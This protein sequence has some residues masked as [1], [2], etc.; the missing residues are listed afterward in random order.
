MLPC[1][2]PP[3]WIDGRWVRSRRGVGR[4][5]RGQR[6]EG[7]TPRRKRERCWVCGQGSWC[8]WCNDCLSFLLRC[9][10]LMTR[11]SSSGSLWQNTGTRSAGRR[12]SDSAAVAD[13]SLPPCETSPQPLLFPPPSLS[14]LFV[15]HLFVPW[16][17]LVPS[18]ISVG[19]FIMERHALFICPPPLAR[20]WQEGPLSLQV[21]IKMR[22]GGGNELEALHFHV[23]SQVV[24]DIRSISAI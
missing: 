21:E 19:S 24:D 3:P 18:I 8:N 2:W 10:S 9:H 13:A 15:W 12:L 11:P 22:A 7:D 16:V 20:S 5:R 6:T 4:Q 14:C 23:A 1:F 17:Y